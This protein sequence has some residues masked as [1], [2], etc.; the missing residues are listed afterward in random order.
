MTT[1]AGQISDDYRRMQEQMHENPNYG[2]ASVQYAPVVAKI[3]QQSG[4]TE[5]LDYGAGKG[6]LGQSL[7]QRLDNEFGAMTAQARLRQVILG[8]FTDGPLQ[9]L[10]GQAGAGHA[11]KGGGLGSADIIPV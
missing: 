11:A 1:P 6:R 5:L 8:I 4:A 10:A 3:L 7:H 2:V 9:A